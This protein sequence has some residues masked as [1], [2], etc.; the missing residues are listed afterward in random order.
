GHPEWIDFP[1]KE[2][3]WSYSYARRQWHLVDDPE[4]KYSLLAGFDRDMIY[5]A[6]HYR[7]LEISGPALLFQH[8]SDKVIAFKRAKLLFV[9][10]FHP[11]KSYVDYRF[12]VQSGKYRMILDSDAELY[13]GHGRLLPDQHY[14]TSIDVLDGGKRDLISLY[15]PTRTVIILE[16]L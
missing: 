10:N 6:Q 8:F 12:E 1:R 2:N 13:G 15:L 7:L 14:E 5:L 11:S 3:S 9:F 4:L 16:K